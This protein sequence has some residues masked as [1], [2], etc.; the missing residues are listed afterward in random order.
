MERCPTCGGYLT[1]E[2]EF[3]ETPARY[4]CI[5]C[6]WMQNDPNFRK[7]EPRY[8][9]SDRVDKRIEWQHL[10][11]GYDLYDPT[12]AA[13]Q[14]GISVSYL[15]QSASGDSLS[16]VSFKRGMIACNTVALQEWWDGKRHHHVG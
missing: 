6:G 8:F 9:P 7:E 13:F 5:A 2:P 16:P 12:S 15:R 10:H 11:P 3:L 4:K 14:L 1:F